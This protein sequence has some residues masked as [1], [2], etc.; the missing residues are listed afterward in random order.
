MLTYLEMRP[1]YGMFLRARPEK[2][3]R[4]EKCEAVFPQTG[5]KK[6]GGEVVFAAQ[7]FNG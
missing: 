3:A 6:I 7:G 4:R 2:S 1:Q 5:N